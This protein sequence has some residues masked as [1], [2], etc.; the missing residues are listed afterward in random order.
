MKPVDAGAISLTRAVGSLWMQPPI[1]T[2]ITQPM[3][4]MIQGRIERVRMINA[5]LPMHFH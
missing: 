2:L 3:S 4:G 5:P 1:A